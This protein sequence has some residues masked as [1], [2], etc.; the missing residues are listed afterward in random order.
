MLRNGTRFRVTCDEVFPAWCYLVPGSIAP[1]EDYDE[2]TGRRT[3]AVDKVTGK[4]LFQARVS[5]ADP[6]LKAKSRETVVKL[7]ADFQP[8]PPTGVPFEPVEFD[9]MTATPYVASNGRLAYSL[10]ATGM[11]AP[12]TA[13]DVREFRSSKQQVTT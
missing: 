11:R 12:A 9:G 7:P 2:K 13:A 6:E 8:V 10:R 5:D 3:P 4:P 1:V